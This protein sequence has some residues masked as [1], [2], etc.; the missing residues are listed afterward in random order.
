MDLAGAGDVAAVEG[1][2]HLADL[3]G[4]EVSGDADH[5]AGAHR[6]E[7]EGHGVVARVHLER[8]AARPDHL[9]DVAGRSGGV[10][11]AHDAGMGGERDVGVDRDR[12]TGAA[13]DVVE[14]HRL[15]GGVGDRAEVRR[16]AALGWPVVVRRHGEDPV[17]AGGCG[18]LGEAHRRGCVVGRRTRDDLAA[19]GRSVDRGAEEVELL[20][21]GEGGRLARGAGDDDGV[22]AVGEQ[23]GDEGGRPVDVE[24]PVVGEGRDHRG[25][26]VTEASLHGVRIARRPSRA[27]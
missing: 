18:V 3:G 21:V 11:D 1:A 19:P 23:V 4:G 15:V 7:R 6:E 9:G 8:V 12:G 17:D 27:A 5:T 13:G 2:D 20:G 26:D 22:V 14:E 25:D 24:G 16:D 10:L